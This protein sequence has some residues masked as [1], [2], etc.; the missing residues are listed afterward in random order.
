MRYFLDNPE[1][2]NRIALAGY[3]RTAA[4]HTYKTRFSEILAR[5]RALRPARVTQPWAL[6]TEILTSAIDRYRRGPLTKWSRAALIGSSKL[7]F[8]QERGPRAARRL[9]YEL[10]WRLTGA[11]TYRAAGLPGRLFYAES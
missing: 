6:S 10:S 4:D 1:E 5:V 3:R 2:R 11:A 9:V 7:I 8:G